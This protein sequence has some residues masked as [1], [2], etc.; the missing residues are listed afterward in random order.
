MEIKRV[1]EDERTGEFINVEFSDYW[2]MEFS[3]K[4]IFLSNLTIT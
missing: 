1:S 3:K 2:R 4:L